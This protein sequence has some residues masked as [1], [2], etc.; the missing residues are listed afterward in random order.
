MWVDRPFTRGEHGLPIV[1]A[2]NAVRVG[3]NPS[4]G[5]RRWSARMTLDRAGAFLTGAVLSLLVLLFA[6]LLGDDDDDDQGTWD[7][8]GELV[9]EGFSR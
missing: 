1:R 7:A 2:R 9:A 3:T 4:F 6:A 5:D 8:D